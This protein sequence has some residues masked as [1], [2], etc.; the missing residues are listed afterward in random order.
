MVLGVDQSVWSEV[1]SRDHGSV[2]G[3]L[4]FLIY[5]NDLDSGLISKILK[6]ADDTKLGID[7]AD[8]EAVVRLRD[9]L[10]K[11]GEWSEKWQMPFNNGKCHVLH[12][13]SGNPRAGYEPSWIANH[14]YAE[15]ARPRDHSDLRV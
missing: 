11:I 12:V 15:G 14:S 9:D 6:F 3:P 1:T 13:G 8:P 10:A 4:L 2:L 7:A 5:M